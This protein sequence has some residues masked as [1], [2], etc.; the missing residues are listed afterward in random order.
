M[1]T[2]NRVCRWCGSGHFVTTG[3]VEWNVRAPNGEVRHTRAV[4]GTL[5]ACVKCGLVETFVDDPLDLAS[6]PEATEVHLPGR[7]NG[8][9]RESLPSSE[10]PAGMGWQV[11]LVHAGEQPIGVI[12]ELRKEL[13]MSFASARES[14]SKLPWVLTRTSNR[15]MADHLSEK[16]SE[17]GALVRI[18]P[19]QL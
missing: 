17:L 11:I 8:G 18:E 5:L 3:M 2:P 13:P 4:T 15:R 9:Y 14:I 12:S 1:N 6:L 7:A 10:S 19:T 16:L